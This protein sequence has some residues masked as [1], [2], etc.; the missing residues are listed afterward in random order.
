MNRLVVPLNL[1]H[2]ALSIVVYEVGLSEVV[3]FVLAV[4]FPLELCGG[5]IVVDM[6]TIICWRVLPR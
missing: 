5:G 2:I 4:I 6:S 3:L 1:I